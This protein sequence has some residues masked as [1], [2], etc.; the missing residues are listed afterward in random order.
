MTLVRSRAPLRLGFGGGGTDVDPYCSLYGGHVLNAT[1]ARYAYAFVRERSDG[2]VRFAALDQGLDWEGLP[3]ELHAAPR[4]LA[5]LRAVYLRICTQYL[6]GKRPAIEVHTYCEAPPG[7]GLGSS[8]TVV[9]ALVQAFQELYRLPLGEY[10]VAHLAYEIERVDEKLAGGRQD[11]YAAAFGGVNFIEFFTDDKVIVNPL[12]ISESMRCELEASLV[13]Y[14]TGVS[15]E[16]ASIIKRQSTGVDAGDA[17]VL[18]ATHAVKREATAM[19]EALLKGNL[20]RLAECLNAGWEAKRAMA[21]GISN[22]R[23]DSIYRKALEAGAIGGK[24]S[25]AGGG[26]FMMFLADPARRPAVVNALSE[27]GGAAGQ[28][29]LCLEGAVAWR[30]RS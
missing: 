29:H 13:T 9:V 21:A 10:E 24:V 8:S 20:P 7:S 11:Q 18:E 3:G 26:G 6:E 14:F 17:A 12:R 25:G 2:R 28:A 5:L 23:I 30:P 4:A 16:S 15:R 19:K 1:I 22:D 27:F